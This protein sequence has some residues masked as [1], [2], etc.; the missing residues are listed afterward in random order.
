[1]VYFN[2]SGNFNSFF[3]DSL[4]SAKVGISNADFSDNFQPLNVISLGLAVPN[5]NIPHANM[6]IIPRLQQMF[7]CKSHNRWTDM[8]RTRVKIQQ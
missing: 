1:V 7:R 6:P 3:F 5:Q 4:V 8:Q 2:T